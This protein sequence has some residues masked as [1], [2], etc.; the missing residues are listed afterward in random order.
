MDLWWD[1]RQHCL[2]E[3]STGVSINPPD[4]SLPPNTPSAKRSSRR[5]S[6]RQRSLIKGGVGGG[7]ER[8]RS[9]AAFHP[10]L[11]KQS[12]VASAATVDQVPGSDTNQSCW[13]KSTDWTEYP[14]EGVVSWTV[15]RVNVR[16]LHS[17]ENGERMRK[18]FSNRLACGGI[19]AGL[20]KSS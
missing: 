2:H 6:C 14:E 17:T 1:D 12:A 8:V 18:Y 3:L 20:Q 10:H 5:C 13:L 11:L 7:G 9:A 4:A 16:L 19:S 15:P